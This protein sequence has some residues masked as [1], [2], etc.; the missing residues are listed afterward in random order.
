MT[1]ALK[2]KT[3]AEAQ[4]LFRRV[5]ALLTQPDDTDGAAISASSPPSR[6]VREFPTRVKCATLCWHTLNAA[7]DQQAPSRCRPNEHART[8]TSP[9][10]SRAT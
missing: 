9:S 7:L 10:C 5:H 8:K 3:R 2:G 4:T 6:G 1:E